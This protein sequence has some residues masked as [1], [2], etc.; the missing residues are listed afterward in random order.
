[1]TLVVIHTVFSSSF[2]P[3]VVRGC[4]GGGGWFLR[5]GDGIK[6]TI[7]TPTTTTI[8]ASRCHATNGSRQGCQFTQLLGEIVKADQRCGSIT[9]GGGGGCVAVRTNGVRGT[10]CTQDSLHPTPTVSLI[11]RST[12]AKRLQVLACI[13]PSTIS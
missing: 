7:A 9:R 11:D 3:I 10:S 6:G 8:T 5:D 4:C 2:V 13:N 1:M 12:L